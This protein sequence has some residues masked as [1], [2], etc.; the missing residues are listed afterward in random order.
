MTMKKLIIQIPCFN[1]AATLPET[2]AALPREIPGIDQIEILIIDDGSTDGTVEVA[3]AE[4]VHHIVR[5]PRNMGLAAAFSAGLDNCLWQGADII[6]NTD[7]DNQYEARDIPRL[8][9]PIVA[10]KAEIVIGPAGG[11]A[12]EFLSVEAKAPGTGQLGHWPC[13]RSEYSRRNQWIPGADQRGCSAHL[14][15]ER[16]LLH[17]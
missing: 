12:G 14:C 10:G 3:R 6:V 9:A 1:E 16:L 13:L 17:A 4:A 5:L 15:L 8:I 2:L 11:D 7:A